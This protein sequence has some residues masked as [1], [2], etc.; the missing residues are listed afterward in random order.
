MAKK[1]RHFLLVALLL[2]AMEIAGCS[3]AIREKT[4]ED[5]YVIGV[6]TKSRKG[7]Y[8]MSVYSGMEKGAKDNGV[9]VIILAPDS[10]TDKV[11]QKRMIDDLIKMK[12]D[13]LAVSPIDSFDNQD[14]LETAKEMDIPVYSYDTAIEDAKVPYI[15]IDNEKAGYD[16][17]EVLAKKLNYHG[18]IAVIAGSMQ[19]ASHKERVDGFCSYVDQ[20]PDIQIEVIKSGY[21]NL[22][23]SEQE[24]E[25]LK[26][27]YPNLDGIMTTSANTAL[28]LIEG[29]KGVDI[30]TIDIQK[31]S[32]QAVVE[33]KITA[34]AAQSGYDIGYETI[35]YILRDKQGEEQ[36]FKKKIEVEILTP[37]NV[38]EY[39]IKHESRT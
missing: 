23:V 16:L 37:E 27:E 6:V 35:C 17:G 34:L 12:V 3:S 11:I 22:R 25:K 9:E 28:G 36:E 29:I 15:G 31:D 20:Y 21:S 13:A 10:E 30:A 18:Q 2:C 24:I 5:K 19:Q 7:E 4:V 26:Q 8:W 32:I 33:G 1:H 39:N 14:Y 38:A